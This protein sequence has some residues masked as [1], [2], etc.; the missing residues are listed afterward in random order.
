M[1]HRSRGI[2]KKKVM[3]LAG[4]SATLVTAGLLVNTTAHA[5]P[6]DQ[7]DPTGGVLADYLQK[8]SDGSLRTNGQG[9]YFVE[10]PYTDNSTASKV[11]PLYVGED[12]NGSGCT[13]TVLDS[14]SGQ[15]AITAEHCTNNIQDG[16]TVKFAPAATG[17]SLP[18][19]GWYVDKSFSSTEEVDG[20]APDVAVLAIRKNDGK[21]ISEET[22]GGLKVHSG[23]SEGESVKGTLLGYPVPD[24]YGGDT[25]AAC[26]GDYTYHPGEGR[27]AISRVDDQEECQIGGGASGGPYLTPSDGDDPEIITV[28]NSNGGSAISDTVPALVDEAEKW[29]EQN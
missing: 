8:N 1:K 16:K 28:L 20:S 26:I 18:I 29:I 10:T 24:P 14:P 3:A 13:A 6:V 5:D 19:G 7:P 17:S 9:G 15:L 11:G 22:G 21:T 25:M 27:S 4:A 12:F 23:V 2:S